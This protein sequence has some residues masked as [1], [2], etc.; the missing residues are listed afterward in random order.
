MTTY[1]LFVIVM[2]YIFLSLN[3]TK[4]DLFFPATIVFLVYAFSLSFVVIEMSKWAGNITN[5]TF[6]I[7]L[8]GLTVYMVGAVFAT[9]IVAK[10]RVKKHLR[11][12]RSKS[13]SLPDEAIPEVLT[14]ITA[15]VILFDLI[16]LVKYYLDVKLSASSVGTFTDMGSMIG[17]Y[18]NAGVSGELEVGISK[19]SV[20]GYMA[21]TAFA[22]LYLYI[23]I[24]NAIQ[25][26]LSVK[27]FIINAA[28]IVIFFACSILTGGRNPLIQLIVAALMMYYLLTK[29]IRGF[30]RKFNRKFTVKLIAIVVIVLIVFSNM[31]SVVGRTNTMNMFDYL[32]MYIGAPIKLFDMFIENP[33]TKAH[34]LFG[35]E[36][37]INMWKWIGTITHDSAMS[38]LIMNK[39]FRTFNGLQLGNVYTAFREYYFDFGIVGVIVLPFIHSVFFTTFY[40]KLKQN[41]MK[42]KKNEFDLSIILYSYL[43]VALV[44][45]SIDDRL[46]QK[47]LSRGT[48]IELVFLLLFAVLLPRFRIGCGRNREKMEVQTKWK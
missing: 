24:I 20:Y 32:A 34:E 3:Y 25:K 33:P 26:K 13:T 7:L 39:E 12:L 30:S 1:L 35:Q 36:T 22:Y 17:L 28:P 10:V 38:G 37:F 23:L 42:W 21:M 14:I 5:K 48:F 9:K 19:F 43:S 29:K 41:R 40:Q 45:Y 16:V 27:K 2:I 31:R 15:M 46:F 6:G 4:G 47:F 11:I 44:Y 18:R 8:I